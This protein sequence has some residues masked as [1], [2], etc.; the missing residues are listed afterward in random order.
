MDFRAARPHE[1]DELG[2]LVLGGVAHWGHD[3]NFP[4]AVASLKEHDMPTAAFIEANTVE[5]LVDDGR[6]VGF[7]SLVDEP[8]FVDLVHMFLAVD[9]IGTGDGRRLFERATSV[10]HGRADRMRI[11]SDPAATGFYSAM[12]ANLEREIEDAPGFMLGL[13]WFDLDH[14]TDAR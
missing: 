8:E 11:L 13:M 2:R 10:A 1:A 3:V 14:R 7:Y 5:A 12:G 6:V 4:D 9:R